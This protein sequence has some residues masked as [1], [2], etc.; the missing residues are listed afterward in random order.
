MKKSVPLNIVNRIF[1]LGNVQ[2]VTSAYGDKV[3]IST[4]AWLTPVE[5]EPP[6]VIVAVDK[7]SYS[8]QLIEKSGE[9]V[10]NTPTANLIE[11]VKFVGSVSGRNIDKVK[12]SGLT[13]VNGKT[14][15]TPSILECVANVE[16][17]VKSIV[18][19]ETH[20]IIM[21]LA[22]HAEVDEEFFSDHWLLEEKEIYLVHHAGSNFFCTT[23]FL[24]KVKSR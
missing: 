22:R 9:F 24:T 5:K 4:V 15:Q 7:N 16:F 20:A 12:E 23:K 13:L 3:N 17:I 8:F 11:I 10:L 19:L 14:I 6:Y 1:N 21:G 18:P 2:L